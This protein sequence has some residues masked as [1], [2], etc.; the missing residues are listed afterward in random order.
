MRIAFVGKGGS[1]KTTVASLFILLKE[2]QT[3]EN[4]WA[5]D[6]DLN[7]HL[8]EQLQLKEYTRSLKSISEA[9]SEKDIK[10]HLIGNNKRIKE[11]SHFKKTTP[12]STNSN[13][14]I[15]QDNENYI[16]KTYS[17]RRDNLSL[18]I[19]GTYQPE[20]IGTSCYH[21]NLGVLEGMLSHTIDTK[22]TVVVDM[23]A[24]ID[25]FAGTLHSQFDMI[26]LVLEPTKK[27]LEVY[28]QYKQL[29]LEAG[30]WQNIFVVG[31]KITTEKDQNFIKQ[32]ID[33]DKLLGFLNSSEHIKEV[34][35]GEATLDFNKLEQ[36]NQKVF[37]KISEMLA[38]RPLS[39]NARLAKL[40]ELHKRYVAQGYVKER[41][42]NLADQIDESFNFSEFVKQY[43]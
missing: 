31:N 14:I 2:I 1:G 37:T 34:E 5:I 25:A 22:S 36:E 38:S 21:N 8:A 13:F 39:Y 18:S 6:A 29:A 16:I 40:H 30:I 12:P 3:S 24:G 19:V 27:S 9:N 41:F 35:Q 4:I 10:K 26:V 28:T 11:I 20:G 43:E 33:S 32:N 7:M 23:V 15:V 17:I 42:G